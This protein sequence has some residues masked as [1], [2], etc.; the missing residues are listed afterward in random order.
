MRTLLAALLM[1]LCVPLMG[2][3]KEAAPLTDSTHSGFAA[4]PMWL[5]VSLGLAGLVSFFVHR[6]QGITYEI[7][8]ASSVSS[9]IGVA[10]VQMLM[11]PTWVG[12]FG[13]L[14]TPFLLGVFVVFL[15]YYTW[16]IG[17]LASI[18]WLFGFGFLGRVIPIPPQSIMTKIMLAE[19]EGEKEKRDETNLPMT[20]FD[21]LE[22]DLKD[23]PNN[24]PRSLIQ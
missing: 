4:F 23:Y 19:L 1:C 20:V 8:K 10:S 3:D 16:W 7:S 12:I 11:T 13:W 6:F 5:K 9:M 15:L 21:E 2:A 14:Q 22:A 17:L 18:V 24:V